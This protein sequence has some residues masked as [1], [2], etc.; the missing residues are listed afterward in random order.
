MEED[1]RKFNALLRAIYDSNNEDN[2]ITELLHSISS[3]PASFEKIRTDRFFCP[4]R[5]SVGE[6]LPSMK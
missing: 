3:I 5:L 1:S 2:P 4:V 6:N